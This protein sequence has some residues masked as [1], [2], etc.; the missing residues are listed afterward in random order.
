[1]ADTKS[2]DDLQIENATLTEEV[3]NL[4][5]RLSLLD[6]DGKESERIQNILSDN[7]VL[8]ERVEKAE[9]LVSSLTEERKKD[10]DLIVEVMRNYSLRKNDPTFF[11]D[12]KSEEE[13]KYE[14]AKKAMED[15]VNNFKE[16]GIKI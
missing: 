10:K 6:K 3:N 13:K 12:D 16:N 4:R 11:G 5:E 9:A 1:M 7:S 14:E 2:I 15:W 8:K